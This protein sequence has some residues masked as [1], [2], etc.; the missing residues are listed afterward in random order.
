[1]SNERHLNLYNLQKDYILLCY[2]KIIIKK[3]HINGLKLK[4]IFQIKILINIIYKNFYFNKTTP[5]KYFLLK[6][7]EKNENKKCNTF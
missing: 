5:E 3:I 7:L 2:K 6:K 1:M 4:I